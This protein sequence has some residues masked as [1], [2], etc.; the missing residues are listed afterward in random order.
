VNL[1][2]TYKNI[3]VKKDKKRLQRKKE[4]HREVNTMQK[5]GKDASKSQLKKDER[6]EGTCFSCGEK[7]HK[8]F[9]SYE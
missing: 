9:K 3:H 6:F 1:N 4:S 2:K 5:A 7:G 8:F